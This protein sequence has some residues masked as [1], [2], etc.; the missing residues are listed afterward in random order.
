MALLAEVQP[1]TT[2]QEISTKISSGGNFK[3]KR[4]DTERQVAYVLFYMWKQKQNN[5][6]KQNKVS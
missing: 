1:G 4:P 2:F 6:N 3:E 5:T